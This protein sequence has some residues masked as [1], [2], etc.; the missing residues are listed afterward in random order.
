MNPFKSSDKPVVKDFHRLQYLSWAL[1]IMFLIGTVIVLG[2]VLLLGG[3]QLFQFLWISLIQAFGLAMAITASLFFLLRL[4][5]RLKALPMGVSML[6]F[7]VGISLFVSV[8]VGRMY[9]LQYPVYVESF[10]PGFGP[11]LPLKNVISFFQHLDQFPYVK[12]IARDPKDVPPPITILEPIDSN[13]D[14][15]EMAS[16]TLK[17]VDSDTAPDVGGQVRELYLETTEVLSEI[18]PGITFNYWTFNNTVPGPMFRIREGDIVKVTIKNS[19]YN[20]HHHNVD[21]HAATGPGGG[22]AVS[23]VKPGES[24]EFTFKALNPGLFVYHCAVP[25]MAVHMA[26]GMYGLILVEPKEGLPAVDKEFYVMQGEIFTT[27]AIG[28]Q[29]LQAFDAKKMMNGVPSYITFNGRPNGVVGKMQ[30]EVG[31]TIRMYVGNGGVVHNSSFHVVGEIFDTVYPE[32]SMG[33]AM[34]KNVQTTNVPAGGST[35]VEFTVDY[36]GTYVLVDHALMRTDKGAWGTIEVAGEADP[37]IF[38]GDFS[39]QDN[40]GH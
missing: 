23:V 32:A 25:N 6:F 11:G 36:P 26:H 4:V 24:K 9:A 15:L 20:L 37:S 7:V 30:A 27:G 21:F 31:D 5:W 39:E 1:V 38:D 8:S 12:D 18:A 13:V 16:G 14:L 2:G 22:G 19:E 40:A 17:V 34:F 33:G 10:G 3:V 29:G 35:I 28:R